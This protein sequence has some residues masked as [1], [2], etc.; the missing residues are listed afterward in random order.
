MHAELWRLKLACVSMIIQLS[1]NAIA[2]DGHAALDSTHGGH[3]AEPHLLN[4]HRHQQS[5][6]ADISSPPGSRGHTSDSPQPASGTFA[7]QVHD[8]AGIPDVLLNNAASAGRSN[9]QEHL[10]PLYRRRDGG[11]PAAAEREQRQDAAGAAPSQ[12]RRSKQQQHPAGLQQAESSSQED[13][14]HSAGDSEGTCQPLPPGPARRGGQHLGQE[15]CDQVSDPQQSDHSP[16]HARRPSPCGEQ[17][18]TPRRTSGDAN[19]YQQEQQAPDPSRPGQNSHVQMRHQRGNVA[20]E[21]DIRQQD[22]S[23]LQGAKPGLTVVEG[24]LAAALATGT[25]ASLQAAIRQAVRALAA[26][27]PSTT[28]LSQVQIM[29]ACVFTCPVNDK[30]SLVDIPSGLE[31]TA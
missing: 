6:R 5:Q 10:P 16:P 23:L 7:P 26:A 4:G 31:V 22:S 29:S 21:P 15:A 24:Q 3:S 17:H 12:A 14:R 28:D 25:A 11:D 20:A 9:Q 30:L 1:I 18:L 13:H 19:R 8:S 27:D 2:G